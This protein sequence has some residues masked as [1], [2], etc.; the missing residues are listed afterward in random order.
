MSFTHEP[1]DARQ[2]RDRP[3]S[4]DLEQPLNSHYVDLQSGSPLVTCDL[5]SHVANQQSDALQKQ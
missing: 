4:T 2:G 1:D 3:S 5:V